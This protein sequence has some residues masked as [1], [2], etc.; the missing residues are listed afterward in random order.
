MKERAIINNDIKASKVKLIG[1]D[2]EIFGII[3]KREALDH[4]QRDKLD[5]V[6]VGEDSEVNIPVCKLMDY[7]KYVYQRQKKAHIHKKQQK[8]NVIKEI[9]IKINIGEADYQVKLR[10]ARGFIEEKLKVKIM[11]RF[12]GREIQHKDVGLKVIQRFIDDISD[13]A[14]VYSDLKLD[15][16][17]LNALLAPL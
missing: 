11:L 15:G 13:I 8:S 4:A 9:K 16:F 12:V 17:T 1:I 6:Q 5:L 2:G 14:V 10:K 7:S 3:S